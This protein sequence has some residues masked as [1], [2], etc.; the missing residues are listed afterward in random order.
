MMQP[1]SSRHILASHRLAQI[2]IHDFRP[3]HRAT[4]IC[5]VLDASRKKWDP[6]RSRSWNRLSCRYRALWWEMQGIESMSP[7]AAPNSSSPGPQMIRND[8][9]SY[10][11]HMRGKYWLE[12]AERRILESERTRYSCARF[13][14]EHWLSVGTH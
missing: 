7:R 8:L 5:L 9:L 3:T 14:R 12:E 11:R 4:Y 2:T 13:V 10:R 1:R 6:K